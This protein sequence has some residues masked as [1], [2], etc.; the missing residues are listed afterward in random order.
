MGWHVMNGQL[1][2]IFI[3]CGGR[4][5]CKSRLEF[6]FAVTF[7][8]SDGRRKF[9]VIFSKDNTKSDSLHIAQFYAL[10]GYIWVL[11]VYF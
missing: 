9:A 10:E 2:V 6:E 4:R 1:K 8:P 3:G 11:T 5:Y 7:A